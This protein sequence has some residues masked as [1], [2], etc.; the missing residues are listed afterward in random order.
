MLK[1]KFSVSRYFQ[2]WLSMTHLPE[3]LENTRSPCYYCCSDK[4]QQLQ[5]RNRE[6]TEVALSPHRRHGLWTLT[7]FPLL[8]FHS[9][10]IRSDQ[11]S[12]AWS[13]YVIRWWSYKITEIFSYI[14]NIMHILKSIGGWDIYEKVL[15]AKFLNVKNLGHLWFPGPTVTLEHNGRKGF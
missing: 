3:Y 9:M 13:F 12:V 8:V 1:G 5:G 2:R 4:V 14:N 6:P 11:L 15:C 10:C 7:D